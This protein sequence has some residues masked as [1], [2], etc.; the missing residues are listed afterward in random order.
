M[1]ILTLDLKHGV[2]RLQVE[3]L[4]D[5]WHLYNIVSEGDLI[6][7]RT[8]R[9]VKGGGEGA[10]P[11]QGK[12]L[13]MTLGIKVK[14][15]EFGG[16]GLRIL[17]VVVEAPERFDGILGS[18]HTLNISPGTVLRLV[19]ENWPKYVVERL[20]RA[21]RRVEHPIIVVALDD[22]EACVAVVGSFRVEVK[23]ERRIKLPG[24]LEAERRGEAVKRYFAEIFQALTYT[25][26]DVGGPVAVVGP[27]F[28]KDDFAR[29]VAERLPPD[30]RLQTFTVSSGGLS[31]VREA[32]RSGVLLRFVR[33]SR[34]L[35][36]AR[37]VE[38]FLAKLASEE[39]LTAY[40]LEAVEK[41]AAL[42]AVEK[43][44]I[45]DKLL[46][47]GEPEERRRL[48]ELI[49]LVEEKGGKVT[50][51][52]GGH[53]AGEKILGLGGLAAILRFKTDY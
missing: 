42:G 12:R 40:G 3:N 22:E 5:L 43:L 14:S 24:K 33:E 41:A 25:L 53:E 13:P 9:E 47:E 49:R 16:R 8:T 7:A 36:E 21:A 39:S 6:Y 44:L 4:D 52:A 50:V 19:K 11:S 28:L 18:H 51:L 30:I 45:V 27:G 37:L 46:R 35:E 34:L 31:G 23:F 48:E 17:G 1:K 15:V 38:E 20:E 26:K 2:A 32:I 10:R 29:Y